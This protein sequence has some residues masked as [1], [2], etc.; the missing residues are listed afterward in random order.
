LAKFAGFSACFAD[1]TFDAS[2]KWQRC[3]K[4]KSRILRALAVVVLLFGML[5]TQACF[6]PAGGHGGPHYYHSYR[7]WR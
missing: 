2:G 3:T 7:Y 4:M 1:G 5:S 6:F